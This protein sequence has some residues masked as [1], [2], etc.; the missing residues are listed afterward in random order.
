MYKPR[1]Y[2][3]WVRNDD[4]VFFEVRE[5]ETDLGISAG[6]N[7]ERQAREAVLNC[8]AELEAYI[9]RHPRFLASLEP[10]VVTADAPAIARTMA[11]AA[12]KAGV[13]PMAAVAGA[14]AEAVGRSLMTFSD[15]GVIVENGGDIFLASRST[16]VVGVYAGD[17]SPF[18]GKIAVEVPAA[19]QGVGV[20]TS[21]G[22]VSHSLSFGKSDAV[23]VTAGSAAL[24]DA[25]ATAAGNT[26]KG[27]EE[28]QRAIDLAR[29]IDGVTGVLVLAG[30]KL[31]SWGSI[32]LVQ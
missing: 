21:S 11:A 5:R 28:I 8:R 27:P 22:T 18:A 6:R 12:A 17:E 15:E 16:R 13:G 20:C 30:K 23:L 3:Q 25:V 10:V 26:L 32:T 4:L 19:P 24:A 9:R 7:L 2:R 29:G 14:I 31:G 1:I